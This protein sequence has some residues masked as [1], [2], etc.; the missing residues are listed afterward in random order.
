MECP[1]AL[2][3]SGL[4]PA[5]QRECP[6]PTPKIRLVHPRCCHQ[7][8]SPRWTYRSQG[9]A[10][11]RRAATVLHWPVRWRLLA[12]RRGDGWLRCG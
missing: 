7:P 2:S 10:A 8:S 1:T 12:L 4:P 6:M 11:A 5:T 9:S 3:T